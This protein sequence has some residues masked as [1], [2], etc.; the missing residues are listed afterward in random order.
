MF[1]ALFRSVFSPEFWLLTL[2]L[3]AVCVLGLPAQDAP[4]EV[5]LDAAAGPRVVA[6]SS[7]LPTPAT[8]VPDQEVVGAQ[9]VTIA[10]AD[11]G[12]VA[13]EPLP[14]MDEHSLRDIMTLRGEQENLFAG[15]VFEEMAL[16]ADDGAFL[17]ALRK[18][19]YEAQQDAPQ[20]S[21]VPQTPTPWPAQ[22]DDLELVEQLRQT[23]RLLDT[24]AADSEATADY[25]RADQL[26]RLAR[27]LRRQARQLAQ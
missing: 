13:A 2:L 22:L 26:R 8:I 9:D 17:N 27:R 19:A 7:A 4:P 6:T 10:A 5:R 23:S 16:P 25:Q 18:V 1:V 21:S 12:P 14:G 11:T 15:T 3:S 24:R 20:V